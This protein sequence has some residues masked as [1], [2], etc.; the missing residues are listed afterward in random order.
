MQKNQIKLHATDL[1]GFLS[2]EDKKNIENIESMY[3]LSLDACK[4]ISA[5]KADGNAVSDL[6]E[7]SKRIGKE[8]ERITKENKRI[9]V[10]SFETPSEMHAECS[11]IIAKLRNPDTMH[12]E[13]L[14]YTQRAYE[15]MF[16]HT[17]LDR[18]LM[19]KRNLIEKTPVSIP[20]QNYAVHRIPDIDIVC[21]VV[22][23]IPVGI[24][25]NHVPSLRYVCRCLGFVGIPTRC[26]P[27]ISTVVPLVGSGEV[28]ARTRD[29]QNDDDY[30]D[31]DNALI[32]HN[33]PPSESFEIDK[34]MYAHNGY[35]SLALVDH[36]PYEH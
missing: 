31:T 35:E 15:L 32:V 2:E 23:G 29:Y 5:D 13:F 7:S 11:R 21:L 20:V 17:F 28:D 26:G 8:L 16:A 14:Y 6:V 27:I 30:E 25:D 19:K 12:E 24:H 36:I 10:Y 1:D 9:H 33:L 3:A 18:C 22:S 4:R 34:S